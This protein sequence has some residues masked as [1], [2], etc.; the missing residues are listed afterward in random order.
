VGLFLLEAA[1]AVGAVLEAVAVLVELGE[2]ALKLGLLLFQGGA[3]AGGA[4]R[5]GVEAF[6]LVLLG[7]ERALLLG[8]GLADVAGLGGEVAGL[9]IHVLEGGAFLVQARG[10]LGDAG[11]EGFEF[12]AAAEEAAGFVG[13]RA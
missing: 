6:E 3:L 9:G 8:E 2:A 5:V 10:K 12:V 7:Q 13:G 4:G 1:E 11:A